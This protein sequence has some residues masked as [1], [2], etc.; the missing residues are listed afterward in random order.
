M[1]LSIETSSPEVSL[2]I[3][4]GETCLRQVSKKG[5]ASQ[6]IENLY[7]ELNPDMNQI[8]KVLI[9]KGPGSYNGLRV[10]YGF[11]KGILSGDPRPVMEI[12]SPLSIA[13]QAKAHHPTISH[14]IVLNNARREEVYAAWVD[15]SPTLRIQSERICSATDLPQF[16]SPPLVVSYD[17]KLGDLS[18]FQDIPWLHLFPRAEDLMNVAHL[19]PFPI[20][21]PLS[22][23]N[24]HYVR[25]P[26]PEHAKN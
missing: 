24:P 23:L 18:V 3:G 5:N 25:P 6:I 19:A 2:A 4:E 14:C 21:S 26:V 16:F 9:S 22:A 8:E 13:V 11:L 7:Q 10:G 15:F 1:L 12:P 20:T 17:Y